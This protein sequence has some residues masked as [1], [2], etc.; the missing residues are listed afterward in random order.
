MTKKEVISKISDYSIP[1]DRLLAV[2]NR[3]FSYISE[4]FNNPD[5]HNKFEILGVMRFLRLLS[6]SKYY[7]N[8][9]EV[10]KFIIFYETLKFPSNKGM[11]SFEL[12]PIQV[13]QFT[14]ILGFYKVEDDTRLTRQALLFV[15]RKYSKTTSVASLAIYDLLF[16]ENDAQAFVGSN[17]FQQSQICFNIIKNSIKQLDP[18]LKN[19]KLNRDI[20]YNKLP[21]KT[22]FVRCLASSADKLDGLNASTVI[23]DEYAAAKSPDLLNVLTSSMGVRKNPLTAIITTASTLL[24]S[25]FVEF[26]NNCKKILENEIQNDEIFAS[27]FMPDETDDIADEKTWFKVQPHMGITVNKAFYKSEYQ[28][29]LLSADDMV[30]FKTKLLN[31]F[32]LPQ[33]QVWVDRKVIERN[34][35]HLDFSKLQSRPQ[36][37]VAVDLSVK[38]DMSAVTYALYDSINHRFYFKNDYYIPKNTVSNHPNKEMYK[39]LVEQGYLKICGEDVIEYSQIA[40]DIINNAKYV[41]ILQLGYDSF[42]SKEFVNIM[43]ASGL[44]NLKA[45][46]QTYGSFTSAVD[47]FE[48]AVY[49]NGFQFDDNPLII[50]NFSNCAI[51][52]DNMGNRKPLKIGGAASTRKIDGAITIL[53]TIKMFTEFTRKV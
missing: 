10:K 1:S 11:Q 45:V 15:P 28:K 51:D 6:D 52:V 3:L 37:M 53:M 29:A 49:K 25:P 13:F 30:N 24:E 26:L 14:N 36:C 7:L 8:D 16:G 18:K 47:S 4:V 17:S 34:T 41:N 2:D 39:S 31:V 5:N 38:D 20:I 33:A 12:T 22:S 23:M 42:K 43:R 19:F 35:K 40:N 9:R 48:I 50:Y 46:S 44:K 27:L 21:N 32:C